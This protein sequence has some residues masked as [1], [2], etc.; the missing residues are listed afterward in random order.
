MCLCYLLARVDICINQS[1]T[2]NEIEH[3][4]YKVQGIT[5]SVCGGQSQSQERKHA[6]GACT[7]ETECS[8]QGLEFT[9]VPRASLQQEADGSAREAGVYPRGQLMTSMLKMKIGAPSKIQK[10]IHPPSS[11]FPLHHPGDKVPQ[12][13]SSSPHCVKC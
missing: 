11:L 8:V 5:R 7:S 6:E 2:R 1:F 13:G 12:G 10:Q 4:I 9:G 3:S